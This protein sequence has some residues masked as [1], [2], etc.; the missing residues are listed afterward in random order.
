MPSAQLASLFDV[1]RVSC[2]PRPLFFTRPTCGDDDEQ[3]RSSVCACVRLLGGGPGAAVVR[4]DGSAER[5]TRL[6]AELAVL[7]LRATFSQFKD[8]RRWSWHGS[9]LIRGLGELW[10]PD[11]REPVP[12]A[13]SMSG[14]LGRNEYATIRQIP[15]R[16]CHT[17]FDSLAVRS[18][19]G[20]QTH[21]VLTTVLLR[22]SP[23]LFITCVLADSGLKYGP[24]R[25]RV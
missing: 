8:L 23:G 25:C 6:L 5:G 14:R 17:L 15:V 3:E 12:G 2:V 9:S 21:A 20:G 18:E 10:S 4:E 13:P 1:Q 22:L 11:A 16:D 24:Y 19:R 7:A